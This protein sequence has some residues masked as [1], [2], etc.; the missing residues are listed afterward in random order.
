MADLWPSDAEVEAV[1][2]KHI[3][4][5][6]YKKRYAHVFDGD[7]RWQSIEAPSGE[8]YRWDEDSTYIAHPNFFEHI[9]EGPKAVL[10]F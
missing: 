4:R 6:M 9:E 8:N 3:S 2:L 10:S 5:D 1:V 7:K